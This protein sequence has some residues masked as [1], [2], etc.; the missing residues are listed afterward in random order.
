MLLPVLAKNAMIAF[1]PPTMTAAA[2]AI[3]TPVLP[4][5]AACRLP[6]FDPT[7]HTIAEITKPATHATRPHVSNATTISR[8]CVRPGSPSGFGEIPGSVATT[9]IVSLLMS[10]SLSAR[11]ERPRPVARSVDE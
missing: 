4:L 7:A 8:N 2:A 6:L 9:D 11:P 5:P 10:A 1:A 3:S